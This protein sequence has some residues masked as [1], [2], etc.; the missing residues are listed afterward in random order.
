MFKHTYCI[1]FLIK[2]LKLIS[3]SMNMWKLKESKEANVQFCIWTK[4]HRRCISLCIDF[5]FER[6]KYSDW[7]TLIDKRDLVVD[8]KKNQ[9]R[10][11]CANNHHEFSLMNAFKHIY[12][13]WITLAHTSPFTTS[14]HI[15]I[16]FCE[17]IE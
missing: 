15:F 5:K 9:L 2:K 14:L 10:H 4:M 8:Q 1:Y 13:C 3:L 17:C 16:L 7:I 6:S 11:D 12:L